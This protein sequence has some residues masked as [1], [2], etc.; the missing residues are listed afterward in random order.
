MAKKNETAILIASLLV[1]SAVLY[2][3]YRLLVG[4]NGGTGVLLP[5]LPTGT[6]A[7]LD[8][9]AIAARLS[10]G[11]RLLVTAIT[12]PAKEA[13]I[14][15]FAA[16]NYPQ[17]I[18]DLETALRQ[19]P[20]DPEALIYLHNARLGSQRA[21]TIAVPAATAPNPA[22]EILR[23]VAQ[24]QAEANAQGNGLPL[25]VVIASDDNQPA[26][27]A[28]I[29]AQ[30]ASD[31]DILAVIGHFGSEATLAAAPAYNRAGLVAISPTSTSIQI[32]GVGKAI[33]RTVPSDRFTANTL[34]Q[35]MLQR[36]Q[37]QKAA[38]FFNAESGY[39][40]SLKDELTTALYSNGGQ[41]V[42]EIDLA[43]PSFRAADSVRQAAQQGAEV[44][45][46][47]PNTATLDRAL[48]IV[49]ANRG[50]LPLLGG[51]SVYNP[52]TL[53]VGGS[54]AEGMAVAVPW[55]VLSNP[56]SPFVV[57]ARRRWGGDVNWR[58]AMAYDATRA[59]L[60]A[61]SRSDNPSRAAILQALSD[62]GFVTTGAT[63]TVRF[64]PSGDRNQSVQIVLVRAG[65]RSGFG[66]DF[67]PAR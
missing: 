51:D 28:Q 63:G 48:Q 40:K 47:L 11:E 31:P 46:L 26:I 1:S 67:V 50:Q 39:S 35:Y 66:F 57:A 42:G 8:E 33:F 6:Q 5:G 27:A 29:A 54:L 62:P 12:S 34:A 4:R 55:H 37:R 2:G 60:A 19:T 43:S 32:S 10:A 45:A 9:G 17:A 65:K 14:A 18:A 59:L 13:G 22:Q 44:L 53:Q 3:G 56:R 20:N 21:A 58:T 16:G 49:A 25:R 41:V 15:A 24:A 64:L 36:M 52:K 61:L 23:G 7:P 30:L 38:V